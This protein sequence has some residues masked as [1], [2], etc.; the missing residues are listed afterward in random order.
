MS[1][2]QTEIEKNMKI[3]NIVFYTVAVINLIGLIFN[4]IFFHWYFIANTLVLV[5]LIIQ[6]IYVKKQYD[7]KIAKAVIEAL[8]NSY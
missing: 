1:T 6:K 7:K 5:F 8:Q 3:W 2:Y 4:L